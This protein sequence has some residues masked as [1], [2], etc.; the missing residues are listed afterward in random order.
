MEPSPHLV[1]TSTKRPAIRDTTLTVFGFRY[2]T[3]P[4]AATAFIRTVF[5]LLVARLFGLSQRLTMTVTGTSRNSIGSEPKKNT[6]T[7]TTTEKTASRSNSVI[8]DNAILT[9]PV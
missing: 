2:G 9:T 1:G 6:Y 4:D 5:L 8:V 7:T 3:P